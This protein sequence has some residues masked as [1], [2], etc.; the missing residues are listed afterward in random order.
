MIESE[1]LG[2]VVLPTITKLAEAVAIV[3]TVAREAAMELGER[4]HERVALW[5]LDLTKTYRELAAAR[6]EWWLQ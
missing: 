3:K 6:H 4:G 1:A 5:A 2:N